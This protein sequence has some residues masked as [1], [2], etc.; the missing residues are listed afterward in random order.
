VQPLLEPGAIKLRTTLLVLFGAVGLVLLIAC[1]NVSNLLLGRALHRRREIAV[2][3]AIG[4][5]RRRLIRQF[6]TE[7]VALALPAAA[8]G[9]L[10][11]YWARGALLALLPP[12][13]GIAVALHLDLDWRVLAF[14]MAVGVGAGVLFGLVP[15]LQASKP[16]VVKDVPKTVRDNPGAY[17]SHYAYYSRYT[18]G[19]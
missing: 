4:A 1:A 13:P 12:L 19:K 11:A 18:G 10:I 9:V 8:L 16:D 14:T 15:A 17:R 2:R 5:N 6:L 7:S 3:L